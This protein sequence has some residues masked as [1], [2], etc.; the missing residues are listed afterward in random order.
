VKEEE[1]QCIDKLE[2]GITVVYNHIP[3]SAQAP[4]RSV[5]EKIKIIALTI[6]GYR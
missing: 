6:E 4:D 2:Q 3:D 1:K 5:D